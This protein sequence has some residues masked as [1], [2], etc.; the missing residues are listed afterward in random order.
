MVTKVFKMDPCLGTSSGEI[1]R[2][3]PLFKD[4]AYYKT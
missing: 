3:H 2:P 1:K 4:A